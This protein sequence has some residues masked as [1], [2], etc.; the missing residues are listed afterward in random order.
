[1]SRRNHSKDKM[2]NTYKQVKSCPQVSSFHFFIP[3]LTLVFLEAWREQGHVF[4]A[5]L[6]EAQLTEVKRRELGEE[7]A[8]LTQG[9]DQCNERDE[10]GL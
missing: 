3:A 2:G 1:M 4:E 9:V 8:Q 10:V 5:L 7:Q 6:Q